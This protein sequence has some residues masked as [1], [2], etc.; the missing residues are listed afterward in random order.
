MNTYAPPDWFKSFM[1]AVVGAY[2]TW[3]CTTSTV[4]VYWMTLKD[5]PP[6]RLMH[7]LSLH[8]GTSKFPPS[9]AELRTAAD[10]PSTALTYAEAWDEMRRNRKLYSPTER[11]QNYRITWSSETVRRA[12]EAVGWTNLNWLESDMPTI[13]AQFRMAYESLDRKR[14]EIDRHETADQIVASVRGSIG[15]RGIGALYGKG[16]VDDAVPE[17][18]REPLGEDG[19]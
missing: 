14:E 18:D 12:A 6:E 7:A 19:L 2:P 17:D 16:Y 4:Q 3:P 10:G 15:L 13:R 11:N 5:I 1:R 8:V 9:A